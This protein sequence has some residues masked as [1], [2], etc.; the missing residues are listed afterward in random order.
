M[1]D[2][3]EDERNQDAGECSAAID[4]DIVLK[5]IGAC[6][7]YQLF[8]VLIVYYTVLPCGMHQVIAVFISAVPAFRC[9]IPEIDDNRDS[10]NPS[11]DFIL[12]STTSRENQVSCHWL[13]AS[14][15]S[16]DAVHSPLAINQ[17]GN[18]CTL[19]T[20]A[21]YANCPVWIVTHQGYSNKNKQ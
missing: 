3:N 15:C 18:A 19:H 17:L 9:W 6:G 11:Y 20:C 12:N 16:N 7:R 14:N 4:F 10:D 13:L 1:R 8:L 21:N 5:Y 2:K